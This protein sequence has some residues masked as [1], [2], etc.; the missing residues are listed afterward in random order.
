M[1]TYKVIRKYVFE[2]TWEVKARSEEEAQD[3]AD[4]HCGCVWPEYQSSLPD[5]SINWDGDVHPSQTLN[6]YDEAI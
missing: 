2:C 3:Y 1:K 5:N 6:E 4:K